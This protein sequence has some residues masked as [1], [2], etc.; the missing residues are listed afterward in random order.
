MFGLFRKKAAQVEVTPSPD[1]NLNPEWNR[2]WASFLVNDTQAVITTLRQDAGTSQ[3]WALTSLLA[4]NGG[5]AVALWGE[6]MQALSKV[7]S[8]S[9]LVLGIVASVLSAH[10]SANRAPAYMFGLLKHMGYWYDVQVTGQRDDAKERE[11]G[12]DFGGVLTASRRLPLAL[13]YVSLTLFIV[14][15]SIAGYGALTDPPK[16]ERASNSK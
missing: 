16:Q 11:N 3:R 2:Q 7:A 8:I 13:G 5:A 4:I 1:L 15:V 12:Q 14:G 10:I 6:D 9:A